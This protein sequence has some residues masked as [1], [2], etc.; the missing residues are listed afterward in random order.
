MCFLAAQFLYSKGRECGYSVFYELSHLDEHAR[1]SKRTKCAADRASSAGGHARRA[2]LHDEVLGAR[3]VAREPP[4]HL[5]SEQNEP[6]VHGCAVRDQRLPLLL[7]RPKTASLLNDV[8]PNQLGGVVALVEPD[9]SSLAA[10]LVCRMPLRRPPPPRLHFPR[11][12][13]LDRLF[14]LVVHRRPAPDDPAF[15][16]LLP[17]CF[18][19]FVLCCCAGDL[20]HVQE[21]RQQLQLHVGHVLPQAGGVHP[22]AG[23][24]TP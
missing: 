13:R 8:V 4:P 9:F 15:L 6:E 23:R 18:R 16:P 5:P 17:L 2:N 21:L 22:P 14:V 20:H 24:N 7:L 12:F 19:L 10:A 11:H 1:T 3:V